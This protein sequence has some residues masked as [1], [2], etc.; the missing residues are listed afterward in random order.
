VPV[1]RRAERRERLARISRERASSKAAGGNQAPADVVP[2]NDFDPQGFVDRAVHSGPERMV[3]PPRHD[4]ASPH[5]QG[6]LARRGL[7]G[8]EIVADG[9]EIGCTQTTRTLTPADCRK[10]I[11][12]GLT[13]GYNLLPFAQGRIVRVSPGKNALEVELFDGYPAAELV[14]TRATNVHATN[15][16]ATPIRLTGSRN[17]GD[18]MSNTEIDRMRLFGPYEPYV[19]VRWDRTL[20]GT[21]DFVQDRGTVMKEALRDCVDVFSRCFAVFISKVRGTIHFFLIDCF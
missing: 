5:D 2:G 3:E 21:L 6:H 18:G 1:A 12:R 8:V 14:L 7:S 9:V 13:V 20:L 4:R 15:V 10:V 17:P 19:A 11:L 16:H